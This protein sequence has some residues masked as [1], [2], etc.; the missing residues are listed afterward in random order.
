VLANLLSTAPR[1]TPP[2]GRIAV[3]ARA[4]DDHV[5]VEVRDSGPGL[6][7]EAQT[8]L[9]AGPPRAPAAAARAP[10][11]AGRGLPIS[12]ALV[13]LHGG[14]LTVASAPGAG[15]TFSFTLPVAPAPG[16]QPGRGDAPATASSAAADATA[17][18]PERRARDRP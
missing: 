2:G 9:L 6:P 13:E 17:S 1:H 15:A 18:R 12:R 7:A 14:R 4:A 8:R 3:A 5:R 16:G 11:G 10:E